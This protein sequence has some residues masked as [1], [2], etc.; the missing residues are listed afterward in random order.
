MD[1][2]EV[3]NVGQEVLT[4]ALDDPAADFI[5]QDPGLDVLGQNRAFGIRQDHLRLVGDGREIARQPCDG[6]AGADATNDSVD[7][8]IHLLPDFWSGRGFVGQG[9]GR[10]AKLVDEDGAGLAGDPLGHVLVVFG[11]ALTDVGAG[12]DYLDA[13]G[14]QVEDLLLRH[15]VRDH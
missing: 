9:I 7:V 11:V 1:A 14:A 6:A 10:V 12:Q 3:G 15:L 13:E 2:R 8:M 5:A 4:D